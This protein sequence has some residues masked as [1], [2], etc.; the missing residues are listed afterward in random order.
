MIDENN[1]GERLRL[2][3][4][5]LAFCEGPLKWGKG[6]K[7]HT[8]AFEE[9]DPLPRSSLPP[10]FCNWSACHTMLPHRE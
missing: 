8:I 5:L 3:G 6:I 7:R 1:R 9:I 4:S 10:Y 2:H